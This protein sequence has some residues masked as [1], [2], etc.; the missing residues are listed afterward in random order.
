MRCPRRRF[1]L[2][3]VA[4]GLV[5][6]MAPVRAGA[7]G[8]SNELW[9]IGT[10]Y[11]SLA[12]QAGAYGDVYER[13]GTGGGFELEMRDAEPWSAILE[14]EDVAFPLRPSGHV[15]QGTADTLFGGSTGSLS[16]GK[17]GLRRYWGDSRRW[18]F[19]GEGG[20]G[21]GIAKSNYTTGR[22]HQSPGERESFVF[23]G[24]AG[25]GLRRSL[26]RRLDGSLGLRVDGLTS[27]GGTSGVFAS[28]RAGL[29]MKFG[30]FA[31]M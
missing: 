5:A 18:G 9:M 11:G 7:A 2:A 28:L 15:I 1:R 27:I 8:D 30:P 24:F 31:K 4:L 12:A 26:T 17:G 13:T 25:L 3:C 6:V 14:F 22:D 29:S 23:D 21:S 16:L 10:L 20:V 19:F